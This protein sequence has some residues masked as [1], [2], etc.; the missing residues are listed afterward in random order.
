MQNVKRPNITVRTIVIGV[1]VFVLLLLGLS[2][3]SNFFYFFERA[4]ANEV[5]VQFV[6]GRIKDVVGPG[7]YSDSGLFV[8]LQRIPIQSVAFSVSDAELITKDKQR[9]GIVVTGD[10]FRP[11]LES[12]EQILQLWAEY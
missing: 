4:A 3:T 1:I 6:S 2:L 11:G 10:V 12:K 9:I 5:G 8:D 7:V